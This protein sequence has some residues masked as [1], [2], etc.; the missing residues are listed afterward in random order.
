[1]QMSLMEIVPIVRELPP[2]DRLRL[3]HILVEDLAQAP[4]ENISP[5]E[6]YKVYELYTPYDSFG[7]ADPLMEL[8]H[9]SE[10]HPQ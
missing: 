2:L 8:L 10:T 9:T 6:P 4:L 3:I 7:V 1:M 5:L